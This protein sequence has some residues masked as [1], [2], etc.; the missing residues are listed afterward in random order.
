MAQLDWSQ[1]AAGQFE[2]AVKWTQRERSTNQAKKLQ[3]QVFDAVDQVARAPGSDR[4]NPGL[5]TK[6]L[7]TASFW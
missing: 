3:Q 6:N 1:R 7:R 4:P 2:Q 5:P